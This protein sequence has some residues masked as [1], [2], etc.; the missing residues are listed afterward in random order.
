LNTR[1]NPETEVRILYALIGE[2]MG[3]AT[4]CDICGERIKS[5]D[6]VSIN[7]RNEPNDWNESGSH[8]DVHQKCWEKIERLLKF[9]MRNLE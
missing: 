5:F 9:Y 1:G 6:A 3:N 2:K 4:V 8:Y 7:T